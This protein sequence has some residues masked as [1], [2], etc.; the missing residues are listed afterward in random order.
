[1]KKRNVWMLWI[2]AI[3]IIGICGY[4]GSRSQGNSTGVDQVKSVP[5]EEEEVK[6]LDPSIVHP[7]EHEKAG[8]QPSASL[9]K[10]ASQTG[11]GVTVIGDSVMV[12]VEPY[13]KERLPEIV[14]DGKVG[15][16]MSQAKEV[17]D[18]LKTQG[19]LG[20]QIILE[21]GTNGPFNKNQL[22]SLLQSLA[23]AQRVVL[24]TTRVP[25]GWQDT[26]NTNIKNIAGEFSN[27]KVVDWYSA[28]EGK[29]DYFYKDGVHLKPDGARYYAS[30]LAEAL[31][32]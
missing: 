25:K 8:R 18:K 4:M 1:M 19:R 24:V 21:L 30:L 22:R 9:A 2:V 31:Q 7:S 29:G 10:Q 11:E 20:N 15:R 12:G 23:G 13:L 28:S 5:L 16:Q 26:V 3:F 17:I 6:P 32:E 14:V 27:A